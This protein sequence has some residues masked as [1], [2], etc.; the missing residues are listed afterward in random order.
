[1]AAAPGEPVCLM[2]RHRVC[3]AH[4]SDLGLAP[5][6]SL[7]SVYWGVGRGSLKFHTHLGELNKV[8]VGGGL[9]TFCI[10]TSCSIRGGR[11]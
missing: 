3:A 2:G 10:P 7:S 5:K 1:M 8:E 4:S 9:G 11:N 6:C